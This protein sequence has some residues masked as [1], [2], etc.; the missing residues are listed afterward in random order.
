MSVSF[1]ADVI[2]DGTPF[3]LVNG[4]CDAETTVVALRQAVIESITKRLS[5][6]DVQIS[7][8]DGK[9]DSPA[10]E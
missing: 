4:I 9:Q 6:C 3:F 8:S 1:K 10:N 7:F 2:M 5:E